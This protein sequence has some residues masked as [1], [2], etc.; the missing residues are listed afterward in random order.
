MRN[1]KNVDG[2]HHSEKLALK[3]DS[4]KKFS[5]AEFF[6]IIKKNLRGERNGKNQFCQAYDLE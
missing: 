1:I 2:L 5:V 3:M 4:L 6:V